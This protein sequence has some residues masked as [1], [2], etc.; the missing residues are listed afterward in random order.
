MKIEN[1]VVDFQIPQYLHHVD[2]AATSLI[3]DHS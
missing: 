1:Y 3:H 2:N